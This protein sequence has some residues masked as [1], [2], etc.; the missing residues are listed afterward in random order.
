MELDIIKLQ[1]TWN[2]A[3]GSL[4]NNFAKIQQAL[5]QHEATAGATYVHTQNSADSTWVI[6]HSL[7]R[8]PSVTVVDS[9]GSEVVGDVT[10]DSDNQVTVRFTA[11]FSGK[12]YLN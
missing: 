9:A 1:T 6:V 10:Y 12:A 3:A 2:D 7:G 11:A 4:N 5:S 8:Y